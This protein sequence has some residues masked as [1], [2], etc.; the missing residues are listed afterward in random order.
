MHKCRHRNMFKTQDTIH[1]AQKGCEMC[2]LTRGILY[3]L[4]GTLSGPV[5]NFVRVPAACVVRLARVPR[6]RA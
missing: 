3:I 4:Q 5:A 2:M 1:R 6:P